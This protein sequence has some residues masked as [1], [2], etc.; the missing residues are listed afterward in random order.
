[1]AVT[2][3]AIVSIR[4]LIASGRLTAGQ[5]LPAEAELAAELG[6]SRNSLREAVRALA[7]AGVLTVRHGDGTYVSSLEPQK[8]FGGL[9]LLTELMQTDGLLEAFQ[10]RRLLEPPATGLAASMATPEDVA[11]LRASLEAM[12]H[13]EGTEE[14]VKLDDQ[15]HQRVIECTGNVTLQCLLG[16]LAGQSLRARI[17]RTVA[18]R[19]VRTDTLLQHAAI[20]EAIAS[21]DS[22]LATAA[23][24]MH[25]SSSERWLHEL[26]AA[27][28]SQSAER[29]AAPTD[30]GRQ[31]RVRRA[32]TINPVPEVRRVIG[33][34]EVHDLLSSRDKS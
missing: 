30:R 15:F 11:D 25:V 4:D 29:A 28:E 13:A 20:V 26:V 24:T 32:V 2:E 33:M 23:S 3:S 18:E 19:G 16:A 8:L 31:R 27:S 7:Q 17:W 6:L 9:S 1:M 10:V 22:A 34:D 5:R 12:S 14:L 21:G